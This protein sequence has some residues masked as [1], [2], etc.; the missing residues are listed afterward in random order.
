MW[1]QHFIFFCKKYKL[2]T[3]YINLSQKRSLAE[4]CSG[5]KVFI[6]Q[7]A[8]GPIHK[9]AENISMSFPHHLNKY[10]FAGVLELVMIK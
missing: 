8:I 4:H 2:Y 5:K 7:K 1:T 6:F 9:V 10:N 3:L